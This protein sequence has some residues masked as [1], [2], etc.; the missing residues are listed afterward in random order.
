M[1]LNRLS[2]VFVTLLASISV[3]ASFTEDYKALLQEYNDKYDA[4]MVEKKKWPEQI[5]SAQQAM[6]DS[7]A[8]YEQSL[9]VVDQ[10]D[11]LLELADR[12]VEIEEGQLEFLKQITPVAE[13]LQL[14]TQRAAVNAGEFSAVSDV[15][16]NSLQAKSDVY[17]GEVDDLATEIKSNQD[18]ISDIE[19]SDVYQGLVSNF[20]LLNGQLNSKVTL[21]GTTNSTIGSL[22]SDLFWAKDRLSD[23][24]DRETAARNEAN[25]IRNEVIP[26]L[27][28]QNEQLE[29]QIEIVEVRLEGREGRRDQVLENIGKT[30]AAINEQ[31][32]LLTEDGADV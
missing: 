19:A 29:V 27:R 2:I 25:R 10:K 7:R 28:T 18:E 13:R 4:L 8:V 21:L 26:G 31:E 22:E 17:Q 9:V 16:K 32:I 15:T 14:G 20:N 3:S 24:E 5:Q 12:E 23:S 6:S 1:I 30:E 11:R